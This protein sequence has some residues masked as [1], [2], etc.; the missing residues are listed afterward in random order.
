MLKNRINRNE[1]KNDQIQ[2]S[3]KDTL[4]QK[5]VIKKPSV[6][7]VPKDSHLAGEIPVIIGKTVILQIRKNGKDQYVAGDQKPDDS[8]AGVFRYIFRFFHILDS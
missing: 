1:K 7:A 4:F 6:D 2:M 8:I 5:R 3:A